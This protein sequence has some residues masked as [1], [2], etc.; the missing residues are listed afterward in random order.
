MAFEVIPMDIKIRVAVADPSLNVRAWCRAN[1]V[2]KSAFYKWKRRY[3]LEGLEGL[4][5]RSRRPSSSPT[6][7]AA[8]VEDDIV[9]LRKELGDAGLDAGADTIRWHLQR[10][11][12]PAPAAATVWRILVRRGLVIAQPRKRPRSSWRSFERAR[13]NECWQ[14][15]ATKWELANCRGVEII[16]IIDDHSRV[17]VAAKAVPI[18][19][20]EQAWATFC[21]AAAHWGLPAEILSDNGAAFVSVLFTTNLHHCQINT[22]N[23]RPYHPQT[24]GKIERF[25]QTLKRRLNQ[26]PRARTLR[27]LQTQLDQFL[28]L[29]NH[30]RPHRGIGRVTPSSRWHDTTPAT[31]AGVTVRPTTPTISQRTITCVGVL[32]LFPWRINVGKHHAGKPV[33]VYHH[34]PDVLVFHNTDVIHTRTIDTDQHYQPSQR[35]RDVSPHTRPR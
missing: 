33:T 27:Q 4:S 2:S 22:I 1:Q 25:H 11:G 9:R 19:T 5:E 6:Q 28:E 13:P 23:S 8:T 15:D 31:P 29:Y 35:V 18:A 3:A 20:A 26:Q 24:C 14:I 34:H 16:D 30:H 7:T 17:V 32:E 10:T 12:K 21:D